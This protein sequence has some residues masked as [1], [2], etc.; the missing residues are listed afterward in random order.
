MSRHQSLAA[1]EEQALEHLAE[2]HSGRADAERHAA[3]AQ[4]R[5]QSPAHAHAAATAEALWNALPRTRAA[6]RHRQG[7]PGRVRRGLPL[8][9]AACLAVVAVGLA[10]P[11]LRPG[12]Y[13]DYRTQ[14]GERRLIELAD[15]SRVWLNSDSALSEDFSPGLRRLRLLRG[16]AL[17]EVA[18]DPARPF[19][20]EAAGGRVRAVGTRFDVDS[21]G[22]RV[23]V[24][25]SEGVVQVDSAG[26]QPVSLAAG[27]RLSYRERG[28]PGAVQPLDLYSASAWQRGK[29]IFNRRPLGEVLDELERYL[30]GRILLTD[31]DLGRHRVSGVFD[32]DDPAALLTTLER[33]Q[34]VRIT[35]LPWLV[36]IRPA[37]RG[38]GE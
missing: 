17:F 28:A 27:Q 23:R 21:R 36:L 8:A 10:L 33:L 30:P 14:T 15:G 16:E 6:R 31:R 2:L 3:F 20:V 34:P 32:L 22:P 26:G 25:V 19:V 1:L 29:L 11:T 5:A 24:D 4:W 7:A 9:I 35:R 38:P 37:P 13:A 12:G 18:K